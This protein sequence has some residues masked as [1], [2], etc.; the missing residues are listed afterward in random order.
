[1]KITK[2]KLLKLLMLIT[3]P[4]RGQSHCYLTA[5]QRDPGQLGQWKPFAN[6]GARDNLGKPLFMSNELL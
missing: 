2:K 5:L 4:H 1:M 3:G 6:G